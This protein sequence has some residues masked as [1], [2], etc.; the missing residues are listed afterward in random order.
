MSSGG[1]PLP[2]AVRGQMEAA[3]G[4][5]FSAVRVYVGPQAARI[6]AIAFT[7]GTD[8]YFAPGRFRPDTVQGKQLLGHELAHVVQQR[9][10]RVR[11]PTGAGLAVVQNVALEAE[12]D[13]LGQ[14][15]TLK[16]APLQSYTVRGLAS[17]LIHGYRPDPVSYSLAGHAAIQQTPVAVSDGS[18]DQF[19]THVGSGAITPAAIRIANRGAD[20]VLY[21]LDFTER[22]CC[23]IHI[24]EDTREDSITAAHIKSHGTRATPVGPRELRHSIDLFVARMI[25]DQVNSGRWPVGNG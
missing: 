19:A 10:G 7:K 22:H 9:Q 3:L 6:G 18:D 13:R 4:A 12:A 14:R 8:I 25:V 15:A 11:H 20:E 23:Q 1:K 16:S 2:D 17:R 5:D 24:H 21:I